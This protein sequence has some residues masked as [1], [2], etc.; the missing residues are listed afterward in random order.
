MYVSTYSVGDRWHTNL[1]RTLHVVVLGKATKVLLGI[2]IN[3]LTSK[4]ALFC[5]F[6]TNSRVTLKFLYMLLILAISYW[7]KIHLENKC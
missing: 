7:S 5:L 2:S 6:I 3:I 4:N 1:I